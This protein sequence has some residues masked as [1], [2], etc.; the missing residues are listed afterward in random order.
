M[1]LAAQRTQLRRRIREVVEETFSDARLNEY[2]NVGLS[3]VQQD[4]LALDPQAFLYVDRADLVSGQARYAKPTG[5]WYEVF[6]KILD[7]DSSEYVPLE[8][9]DY[10]T[11]VKTVADGE[12]RVYA[13]FGRWFHIG[14][15]PDTS[16]PQG[17]ELE[18]VPLLVMAVDS[19]VPQ[20][21]LQLH[22]LIVKY[23]QVECFGETSEAMEPVL[24]QIELI[25]QRIPLWYRQS[26]AENPPLSL[27]IDKGY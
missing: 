27:D 6:L 4:V 5:F 26:A 22:D 17:I 16:I 1:D 13:H 18:Y 20:V 23:A 3:K 25:R 7:T 14:P 12:T 11:V 19:D 2:L 10:R 15:T 21:P 9:R 8:K 24:A